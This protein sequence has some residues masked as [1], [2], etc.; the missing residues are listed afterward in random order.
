MN[1]LLKIKSFHGK[2]AHLLE[3]G[4]DLRRYY[5]WNA[6]MKHRAQGCEK[7]TQEQDAVIDRLYAPYKKISHC[8]HQF[9]TDRTGA[10][11]ENYIPDSIWY[12]YIDP[13]YNPRSLAK[14]LDS[15]VLYDRLLMGGVNPSILKALHTELMVFGCRATS[16]QPQ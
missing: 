3:T 14:A 12:A 8:G 11:S 13:F 7:L 4:S 9:Y 16:S 1:S 15:K 10:F 6:T 2:V 5:V